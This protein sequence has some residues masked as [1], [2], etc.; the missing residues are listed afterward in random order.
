MFSLTPRFLVLIRKVLPTFQPPS[1]QPHSGTDPDRQEVPVRRAQPSLTH[2]GN[3]PSLGRLGQMPLH[4]QREVV[5][6]G[7][8]PLAD[9]ALEGLRPRVFPVVARQL[10]A[11]GESPLALR[12]LA[13]VRLL[14]WN[15]KV[16]TL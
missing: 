11:A 4:V 6:P 7:K 2:S 3:P 12:P 10:V 5:T 8:G 14:A 15:K 16:E 13:A 9:R 1:I